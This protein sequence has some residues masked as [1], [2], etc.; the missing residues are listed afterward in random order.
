MNFAAF[1]ILLFVQINFLTPFK[2][3]KSR[4]R[5]IVGGYEARPYSHPYMLRNVLRCSMWYQLM[6]H[7]KFCIQH[8]YST[9]IRLWKLVQYSKVQ[10]QWWSREFPY[11]WRSID[12][13]NFRY[14]IRY[15]DRI[16]WHNVWIMGR[17]APYQNKWR[18][19]T[20]VSYVISWF[21]IF[22]T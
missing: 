21:L 5:R 19:W 17:R 1:Y 9:R 4:K 22:R 14:F 15:W 7:Q 11:S 6:I 2:N 3:A 20:I 13:R 8:L 10:L 16:V 12:F 18:S